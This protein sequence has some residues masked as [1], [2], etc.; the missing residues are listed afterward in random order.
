MV[1]IFRSDSDIFNYNCLLVPK[2]SP[3]EVRIAGRNM[4]VMTLQ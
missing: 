4:L 3:E 1:L 2:K